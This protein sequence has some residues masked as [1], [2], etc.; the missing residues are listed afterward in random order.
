M[1]QTVFRR[2]AKF[3]RSD[4]LAD[5]F[6][7]MNLLLCAGIP[8]HEG[9]EVLHRDIPRS[10]FRHAAQ[11]L[12]G[13]IRA[14]GLLS[15]AMAQAGGFPE[16]AV[17]MIAVGEKTG[18][19]DDVLDALADYYER[20]SAFKKRVT[21]AVAYPAVLIAMMA[22]VIAVIVA[23]V[24]PIFA[25]I[26]A[27][28]G[29]GVPP[30]AAQMMAFSGAAGRAVLGL[31]IAVVAVAAAALLIAGTPRGAAALQRFFARFPL[32]AGLARDIAVARFASAMAL[33][34]HSGITPDV[35]LGMAMP[36]VEN[37]PVRSRLAR[38]AAD[39]AAGAP[40]ETALERAGVFRGLPARLLHLGVKTGR[41]DSAMR[42]LA[43]RCDEGVAA[44]LDRAA[45]AIEPTLVALLAAVIGVILLSVMLPLL[46]IMSSIG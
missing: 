23:R 45:A 27:Q 30:A 16:H 11:S 19:T 44:S 2:R 29:A 13:A 18:K 12:D 40:W 9:L 31:L 20:M 38:A 4:L 36:A 21:A 46:S 32:T 39:M 26:F 25:D 34:L 33:M 28:M 35:A 41:A 7:Q 15:D 17:T 24:L 43:M 22:A 6:R 1:P 42:A 37:K 3:Y 5:L 14:G 10:A 8:L